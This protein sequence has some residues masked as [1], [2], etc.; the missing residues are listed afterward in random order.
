MYGKSHISTQ[1]CKCEGFSLRLNV[2]HDRPS[3][4]INADE[5]LTQPSDDDEVMMMMRYAC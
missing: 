4:N 2:G 3:V 1:C 5:F